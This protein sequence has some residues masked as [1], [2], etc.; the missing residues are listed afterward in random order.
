L[1]KFAS[2]IMLMHRSVRRRRSAGKPCACSPLH[3]LIWRIIRSPLFA[4]CFS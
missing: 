3:K 4:S 1:E 2:A